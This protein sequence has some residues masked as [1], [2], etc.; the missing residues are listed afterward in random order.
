M[1][2]ATIP[3]TGRRAVI[4]ALLGHGELPE[5]MGLNEHFWP[6]IGENSWHAQGLPVGD[7][8]V[9]RFDLDLRC[10]LWYGPRGPRPDLAA[11]L[12]ESPEWVVQRDGWGAIT[13]T[14]KAKAGTPEHI[15]FTI[16]SPEIWYRDFRD[17]LRGIDPSQ[18][19]DAAAI[20][21]KTRQAREEDRFAT[22]SFMF[23]F[24][25][26]RKVLGDVTMLECLMLEKEFIHDFNTCFT[27]H[28]IAVFDHLFAAIG[29]PDGIHFYEDLGYTR[30]PF[31]SPRC[32][33]EMV[34][35]Y[36]RRLFGFFKDHGLPIIM[37]TCGDF[38]PHLPAMVEAGVDCV[39]AL[40][41]KTGMDVV[42]L[43]REWKDR[44]CFMGNLDVRAY[45][46]GDWPRLQA[47]IRG[48]LRGM[49]ELRAPYIAMSDHSIPP[50]VTL[51]DFE[52]SLELIRAEWR[53]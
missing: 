49:R 35:P 34:Q 22:W 15:G 50:T 32:H 31:A 53:Y 5:R 42:A 44:L 46:S 40:E 8:V 43:A 51:A 39:Q 9:G 52:R 1:A 20:A 37:H 13:K 28:F 38:R 16:T 23:V 4:A 17:G 25:W 14:W 2:T 21:E 26:M 27:D 24:E 30:A 33:C 41:A 11:T 7:D 3:A 12:E 47:E 18:A 19:V 10:A 36:H 45:E 29:K 48:K 6:H